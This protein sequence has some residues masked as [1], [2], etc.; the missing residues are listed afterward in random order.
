MAASSS[1]GVC[2]SVVAGEE[3]IVNERLLRVPDTCSLL[4]GST[5]LFLKKFF[6]ILDIRG[7]AS[8]F[9]GHSHCWVKFSPTDRP[10]NENSSRVSGNQVST[11]DGLMC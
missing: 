10:V 7:V 2:V 1:V 5:Q 8:C 3:V 11:L 6:W 9:E 4:A